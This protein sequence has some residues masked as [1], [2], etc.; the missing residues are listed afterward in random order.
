MKMVS[1]CA[2][3]ITNEQAAQVLLSGVVARGFFRGASPRH[4]LE[5]VLSRKMLCACMLIVFHRACLATSIALAECLLTVLEETYLE[6]RESE[7]L[8]IFLDKH[9]VSQRIEVRFAQ[10]LNA[11][12][13]G[14]SVTD[15]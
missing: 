1:S 4:V 5:P 13:L 10:H 8:G 9:K 6:V 11:T 15:G 7:V 14:R 3:Q 12:K 2:L